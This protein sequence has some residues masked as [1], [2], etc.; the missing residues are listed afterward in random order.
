MYYKIKSKHTQ[1]K[2]ANTFAFSE[3]NIKKYRISTEANTPNGLLPLILF[4]FISFL[5]RAGRGDCSQS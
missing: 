5:L 4:I 3:I 1:I 2:D